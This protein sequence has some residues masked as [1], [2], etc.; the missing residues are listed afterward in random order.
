MLC[1]EDNLEISM[2]VLKFYSN[3]TLQAS[4]VIT[5][6]VKFPRKNGNICWG[7]IS[8]Y[9]HKGH[10]ILQNIFIYIITDVV[11]SNEYIESNFPSKDISRDVF[12]NYD[13]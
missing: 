13:V 12:T 3:M 7:T 5:K 9:C 1:P 11:V 8:L 6:R 4:T 2:D 10:F